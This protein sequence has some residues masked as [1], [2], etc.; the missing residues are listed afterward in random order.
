[1]FVALGNQHAKRMRHVILSSLAC[2]AVP[3]L[4]TLLHKRSDFLEKVIEHKMG[5][6]FS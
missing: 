3:Y 2:L 5:F 4:S 6:D 1:V